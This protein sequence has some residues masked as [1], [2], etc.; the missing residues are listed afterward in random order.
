MKIN[1]TTSDCNNSNNIIKKRFSQF[2]KIR[3]RIHDI[4]IFYFCYINNIYLYV[5]I[6]IIYL[7]LLLV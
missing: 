1:K 7:T 2:N 4:I 3:K 6:V 5:G